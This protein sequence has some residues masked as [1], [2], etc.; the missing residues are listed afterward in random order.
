MKQFPFLLLKVLAG[1]FLAGLVVLISGV[2]LVQTA[3]AAII[4][5]AGLNGSNGVRI[6]GAAV[7]HESGKIIG[8]AGDLNGDGLDDIVIGVPG[9]I[10]NGKSLAGVVYVVF[11]GVGG[12]PTFALNSLTA[13]EGFR[14][15]GL[16][17]FDQ[18]GYAASGAGDVNRDGYGDLI[19]GAPGASHG[20]V[21]GSGA[22]FVI[23]GRPTFPALV[24][25][26]TL[27]GG[28]GFRL[29]GAMP[30]DRLGSAAAGGGDVNGDGFDD[31][32]IGAPNALVSGKEAAGIAYVVY[33]KSSFDPVANVAALNGSNGVRGFRFSG[34]GLED[35]TGLAVGRAGDINRDGFDDVLIAAP[36]AKVGSQTEVGK[37]YVVLG[38]NTISP[39]VTSA[40]LNGTVGFRVDGVAEADH[41]GQSVAGA[42]DVNGD[43]FDDMVIGAPYA[44]DY[45]GISYL[46]YGKSSFAA[47]LGLGSLN[48]SNGF[49]L[50]GV[51]PND[52]AGLSVSSAG[53]I[54]GDGYD[55]LL[56][57]APGAGEGLDRFAGKSHIVLGNNSFTATVEL[58]GLNGDN[59]FTLDGVVA[60]DQSGQRVSNAGDTNGD[61]YDDILIGAPRADV[62]GNGNAG[63][64]YLIPGGDTLGIDIP[65]THPGTPGA[66]NLNGTAANDYMIA[67][68]GNDQ[69]NGLAGNDVL[70]GAADN[71]RLN[72]GPGGDLLEGDNGFDIASYA[73]SAAGVAVN[74]LTGVGSGGDAEGDRLRSIE[75]L[76][77]S[78][79]ADTLIGDNKSNWFDGGG[80]EDT[81]TGHGGSDLF[82]FTNSSGN[83]TITDFVPGAGSEDVLDFGGHSAV[84]GPS[85]LTVTPLGSDTK[86]T[87]PGDKTILL[88]GVSSSALHADDYRFGSA[89][90]AVNDSYATPVN[91]A[92]A[93]VAPGV[94]G[95]DQN[96]LSGTMTA[97]VVNGPTHGTLT[98]N[99]SGS[100]TYTPAGGYVGADQFTYRASNGTNSNVATV[101]LEVTP[102]GPT[103]VDDSYRTPLETTLTI[104]APGV[105]GN[106]LNPGGD[107][108]TATLVDT[109]TFGS[110]TLNANGSFSYTPDV[111]FVVED[112]FTYRA[113]N[114]QES[115]AATVTIAVTNPN[116]PPVANDDMY[117]TLTDTPLT[118][119]APGVLDNDFDPNENPLISVIADNVTHGNLSLGA[120]GSFTY[121][122]DTHYEGTDQ[123]TYKA[124]G[125]VDSAEATVTITVVDT[126]GSPLAQN[127]GYV[128]PMNTPLDVAAPG[129]LGNDQNPAAQALTAVLVSDVTH[130]LLTLNSNGSFAYTP[131]GNF[132]GID[133]FR[134]RANNGQDS[135]VAT[136]TITV[137]ETIGGFILNLP[138]VLAD[139]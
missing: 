80:G 39:N 27:N 15:E 78:A 84:D 113:N 38:G 59:G 12:S 55:D 2:P 89:P 110:V 26:A 35:H 102:I 25:L 42:G 76:I 90:L 96:P 103:A 19:L 52:Q 111:E 46:I 136:V 49:K 67:H 130:G 114:G 43:G 123:F 92:L 68:R 112:S 137:T 21:D 13:N 93:V 14:V 79:H 60:G 95:N 10:A 50:A 73:G 77:G 101:A 62:N 40:G 56:I 44:A 128:I 66:N 51:N 118:I 133:S 34:N 70:K 138:V 58:S 31:L 57:G 7:G 5:L 132:N 18:L 24:D 28:N 108:L 127:D 23:F 6:D 97:A 85:D 105:L 16:Y 122:P 126:G 83:T 74:L 120:D 116:E 82:A 45:A 75:G 48:G 94:L 1:V 81:I 69:L 134:Y 104:S 109:P 17:A 121:T 106:D 98:L 53:D 71:D 4:T 99:S 107:A 63:A 9:A 86:I 115:N 88:K 20:D 64:S 11:G 139:Q 3:P 87:L 36:R 41:A 47:T 65:V 117:Q 124:R 32:V 22:V 30:D 54:D 135:N 8:P 72:G 91:S 29:D 129:V 33:G 37:V 125:K 131:T 61:G 119:A 100:F